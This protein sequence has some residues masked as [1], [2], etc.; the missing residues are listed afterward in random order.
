MEGKLELYQK[1]M[2]EVT[3]PIYVRMEHYRKTML[4]MR[5]L[6]KDYFFNAWRT[7]KLT[8]TAKG[9]EIVFSFNMVQEAMERCLVEEKTLV[10]TA[11]A[12]ANSAENPSL[13]AAFDYHVLK[14]GLPLIFFPENDLY[15]F[16]PEKV[17]TPMAQ[18]FMCQFAYALSI[19]RACLGICETYFSVY[20]HP[21]IATQS[22][23]CYIESANLLKQQF[24]EGGDL[25]TLLRQAK[26]KE[27]EMDPL[28][29][30]ESVHEG[31]DQFAHDIDALKI[32]LISF[33]E[34]GA[35]HIQ[36]SYVEF[37]NNPILWILHDRSWHTLLKTM[38]SHLY[39]QQFSSST[40][41]GTLEIKK[42]FMDL[43]QSEIERFGRV[44]LDKTP[45]IK[46]EILKKAAKIIAETKIDILAKLAENKININETPAVGRFSTPP[47]VYSLLYSFHQRPLPPVSTFGEVAENNEDLKEGNSFS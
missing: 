32:K 17:Y 3:Q 42:S 24:Q 28:L 18:V 47:A 1:E 5:K 33:M 10:E 31:L 13:V 15:R 41:Y 25:I 29:R 22:S 45:S 20:S 11:Q 7:K 34:T 37:P 9:E 4:E 43:I 40:L 14:S 12:I 30:T 27:N 21:G 35:E 8:E 2:T 39:A 36:K 23:N 46:V 19:Y 26:I 44:A 6:L 16:S 38:T